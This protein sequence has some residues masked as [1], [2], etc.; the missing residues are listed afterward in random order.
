MSS[1]SSDEMER[2]IEARLREVELRRVGSM[3][4]ERQSHPIGKTTNIWNGLFIIFDA[5]HI[6]TRNVFGPSISDIVFTFVG[7]EKL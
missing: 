3:R 7:Y 2:T 4:C 1:M 5:Q 6:H